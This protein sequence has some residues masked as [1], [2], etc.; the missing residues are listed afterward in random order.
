MDIVTKA[1]IED[2]VYFMT[3]NELH[4]GTV[5]EIK[6]T[7]YNTGDGKKIIIRY[8][9]MLSSSHIMDTHFY[10]EDEI[11]LTSESLVKQLLSKVKGERGKNDG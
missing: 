6:V 8:R 7:V 2:T 5:Q 3:N 9:M 4:E 1:S 10:T 11:F